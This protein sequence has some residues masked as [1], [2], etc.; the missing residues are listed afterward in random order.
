MSL[1]TDSCIF[2]ILFSRLLII[3]SI[4]IMNYVAGSL[5][6]SS[7]FI[8]T[9]VFLVCSFIISLSSFFL[10][11]CVWD[12]LFPGFKFEFFLH[13]GSALLKSSGL[14]KLCTGWDLCWV[15]LFFP[16]M[17]RAEWGG[18]PI[19]W[20][21]GLHFCPVCCLDRRPSQGTTGG[22]VMPGLV[23]KW[24]PLWAFSVLDTP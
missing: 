5:P 3:F 24:F 17:G 14:C 6:I 21:L 13:L 18:N 7:L 15:L 2:S 1:L 20:W 11:Y 4:I 16:L 23:F 9:S 19:C 22:W 12:L 8:W 10:T